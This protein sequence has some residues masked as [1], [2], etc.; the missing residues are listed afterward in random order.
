MS[1]G[2]SSRKDYGLTEAAL[3]FKNEG[4]GA[5]T[6]DHVGFGGSG[7]EPR[8]L[9][10]SR[11]QADSVK[12]V[13][14]YAIQK[15]G[16]KI[17]A[18]RI[19]LWGAC[20]GTQATLVAAREL[21]QKCSNVIGVILQTPNLAANTDWRRSIRLSGHC[22]WPLWLP[23]RLLID[24]ITGKANT[25]F[26]DMEHDMGTPREGWCLLPGAVAISVILPQHCLDTFAK[27]PL[28][29]NVKELSRMTKLNGQL[30]KDFMELRLPMLCTA[31]IHEQ[32]VAPRAHQLRQ[33]A[34]CKA[35]GSV[36]VEEVPG[37]HFSVYP[38]VNPESLERV[39]K[40]M[41][42][43]ETTYD[44]ESFPTSMRLMTAWLKKT[45]ETETQ[46]KL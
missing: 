23:L 24:K 36:Q 38:V 17:D 30:K 16:A 15:L 2:F 19:I 29:V 22:L 10:D 34:S 44:A 43:P 42:T 28:R 20:F 26:G 18:S 8:G 45:T 7:G 14:D 46:S 5:L 37:E 41:T 3:H 35:V 27:H 31:A 1:H 33:W 32:A 39:K 11:Q 13:V 9:V 6:F 25:N 21:E 12:S 4:F 40:Y